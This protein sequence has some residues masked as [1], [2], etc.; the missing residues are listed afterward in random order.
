MT[1]VPV[2]CATLLRAYAGLRQLPVESKIVLGALKLY[3]APCSLCKCHPIDP[4]ARRLPS[5]Q[6]T[7]SYTHTHTHTLRTAIPD[8]ALSKTINHLNC[9]SPHLRS[10][11]LHSPYFL[12]PCR[13]PERP[14]AAPR[15]NYPGTSG[16]GASTSSGS[17]LQQDC[18][19]SLTPRQHAF[20][21]TPMTIYRGWWHDSRPV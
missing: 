21:L 12:S 11:H 2:L 19:T 4:H 3:R 18:T 17:W 13:R 16:S 1:M 7:S 9:P 10:P 8:Q 6:H 5:P 20:H 14:E 15:I